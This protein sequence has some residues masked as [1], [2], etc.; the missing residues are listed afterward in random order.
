LTALKILSVLV[1]NK[2]GMLFRVAHMIRLMRL[3]IEGLTCG[4]ANGGDKSRLTLTVN[5][6]DATLDFV[7]KQLSKVIDVLEAKTYTRDQVVA[8]ELAI[9]KINRSR[10]GIGRVKLRGSRTIE[11]SKRS[12]TVEVVGTPNEVDAFLK[13]FD[14]AQVLELSRTGTTAIPRER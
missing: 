9:L 6:D 14:E 11:S 3:N 8:R 5:G 2:P 7:A 13:R 1:E 4:V 12:T 10:K